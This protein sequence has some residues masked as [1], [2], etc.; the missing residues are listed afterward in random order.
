MGRAEACLLKRAAGRVNG[1]DLRYGGGSM[2]DNPYKSEGYFHQLLQKSIAAGARDIHLK[3]GQP[4][5]AR[6][7]GDL[8]FFR[9]DELSPIHTRAVAEHLIYD[10]EILADIDNLREYDSAY[11]VLGLGRFR[12]NIYRQRSSLAIV[13]RVVPPDVPT[14]DELGAPAVC[15]A[16]AEKE[17]GLILCVGAAGNGKSSTL[18]AMVNHMNQTLPRHIV[19]IEDPIEFVHKDSKSSVSQREIGH[20]T[21]G[22]AQALRAALRPDPDVIYVGEIRDQETMRIALEAAETGHL[23]LSTLHTP[24]VARTMNRVMSLMGDDSADVRDR[25]GDA[26][27]GIVAQRLIRRGDGQGMA[28]AAEVLVGTGSVNETITRPQGN[29]SIKELMTQGADMYGMQTFEMSIRSLAQRGMISVEVA[30]NAL[31]G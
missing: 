24:D 7:R 11:E 19:T 20:D 17:R 28:L 4:P 21:H 2:A 29:P 27:Q 30:K 18:A 5:G 14:L 13:M 25:L 12:V 16:L 22:F 26:I 8:V 23:V 1:A 6:V 15:K 31:K 3:V 10:D 9:L